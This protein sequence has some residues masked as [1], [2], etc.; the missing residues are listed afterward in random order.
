MVF[1]QKI[2]LPVD[3]ET[4]ARELHRIAESNG[5][6]LDPQAV[7]N[8]SRDEQAVLHGLFEWDDT[9][10]A[11]KY[12]VVQAKFIIR[13]VTVEEV[14]EPE[15]RAFSSVGRREYVPTR[16]ALAQADM[17]KI[18]LQNALDDIQAFQ[19]KYRALTQVAGII[20][21]MDETVEQIKQE[22]S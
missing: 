13:N 17:R 14:G 11:E 5:G 22:V 18:V 8:A 21:V 9:I 19:A 16:T 6:V 1:K 2:K 4:T 3:A 20:A 12:R 15:I 7:V 10:A